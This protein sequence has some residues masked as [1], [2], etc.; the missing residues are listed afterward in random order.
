MR[1]IAMIIAIMSL[2]AVVNAAPATT[3]ARWTNLQARCAIEA[4]GSCDMATGRWRYRCISGACTARFNDCISRGR[5]RR[6]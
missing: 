2:T 5:P 1:P 4:G 3:N 6:A